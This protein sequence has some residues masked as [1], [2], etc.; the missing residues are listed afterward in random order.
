[1]KDKNN[2]LPI[3]IAFVVAFAITA[4]FRWL[5]PANTGNNQ[6]I[7]KKEVSL[8]D[9]PLLVKEIKKTADV[10][11]I[12]VARDIKK[13]ERI[14]LDNITWKKWPHDALQPYFIAKDEKGNA[15][16]NSADYANCL[17]MW[18]ANDIQAGIPLSTRLLTKEDPRKKAEEEKK[19]KAAAEKKKQAEQKKKEASI[20][21]KGMR[22]ITFSIDQRSASSSSLMSPG[23]IVDVLILEPKGDK[24][25]T[26]KYKALKILAIDGITKTTV[27]KKESNSGN[28][29]SEAGLTGVG[30]FLNP[31]NVTLEIKE[32]MV[33]VMI[34]QASTNGVV[35][36]LRPQLGPHEKLEEEQR[37]EENVDLD[38][39]N[40]KNEL[41]RNIMSMNSV[42]SAETML[43]IKR[44]K[45]EE[46]RNLSMLINSMNSIGQIRDMPNIAK[47]E[48][49]IKAFDKKDYYKSGKME[50]V[51][52][53][54]TG[55]EAE[56]EDVETVT[57][58]RKLDANQI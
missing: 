42:N 41:L 46:A 9:I 6:H 32:N 54:T 36:S 11:V 43:K 37:N 15:L 12:I 47:S 51:R 33:D 31:R 29:L 23:D 44:Q 22:A 3:I 49:A 57:L 39:I 14:T 5:A 34:K 26:H 2:I 58:Y 45:E 21:R 50:F 28:F 8:P 30:G 52:G 55:R 18:A 48:S 17:E 27:E 10:Q 19:K 7:A 4:L 1:M 16:N 24:I 56:Q 13:N 20:I 53:K 40:I 35:L 25:K 38:D